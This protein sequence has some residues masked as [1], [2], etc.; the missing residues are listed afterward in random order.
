MHGHKLIV[1][2]N[3]SLC[4]LNVTDVLILLLF[5]ESMYGHKLIVSLCQLLINLVNID[6]LVFRASSNE[7][8]HY[9]MPLWHERYILVHV[10]LNLI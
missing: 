3:V 6:R 10:Q 9:S 2:N 5:L 8:T 4:E 7:Q 1:G